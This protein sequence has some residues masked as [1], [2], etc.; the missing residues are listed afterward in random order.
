MPG[1]TV[2]RSS[3][4]HCF[5]PFD[6]HPK[7]PCQVITQRAAG[8]HK[9]VKLVALLVRVGSVSPFNATVKVVKRESTV[10]GGDLSWQ[11]LAATSAVQIIPTTKTVPELP[12]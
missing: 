4:V 7:R 8:M 6:R 1:A 2:D 10:L 3:M 9:S 11:F 5:S 12:A